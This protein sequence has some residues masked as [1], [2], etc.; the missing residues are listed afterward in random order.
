MRYG[1]ILAGELH[2]AATL[3]AVWGG[4]AGALLGALAVTLLNS[5]AARAAL[6]NGRAE[7]WGSTS[8]FENAYAAMPLTVV[9]AV[10]LGVVVISSEYTA[11]RA[12]A[13][14]GR[15]IATTLTVTPYRIQ[16]LAAK[17]ITVVVGVMVIA[18]ATLL[19]TVGLARLV[20]GGGAETVSVTAAVTRCLGGTLYATLTGLIAFAVTVLTRS[21]ILPLLVLIM[22]STLVSGSL[23]LTKLTPLAHWLPDLAGRRL[24]GG[25]DTVDGGLAPLPGAIV[26]S[27]WTLAL[28][29]IAGAVF[30]RRDA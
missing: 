8:P 15:Q 2:K 10:V 18:P 4:V 12:D 27:G 1:R 28:L 19:V 3:P 25:L 11:N 21:G 17:A 26:M 30:S 20:I 5:V 7:A 14:G 23:L 16:V 13:G 22:N 6:E 24:F 9:G 29:V